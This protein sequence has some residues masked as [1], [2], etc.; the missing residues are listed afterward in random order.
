MIRIEETISEIRRT[1]QN[2]TQQLI[3]DINR[4]GQKRTEQGRTA[5][6]RHK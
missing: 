2:R 6:I 1:G 4:T 5:N 3:S